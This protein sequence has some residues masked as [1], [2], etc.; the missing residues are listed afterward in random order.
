MNR[1]FSVRE[2][3]RMTVPL[4]GWRSVVP[5]HRPI[6]KA[7]DW[8][9][10]AVVDALCPLT[11]NGIRMRIKTTGARDIEATLLPGDPT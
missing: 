2:Y 8:N 3:S 4:P 9:G 6:R 7:T 5:C 11:I 1:E 10:S